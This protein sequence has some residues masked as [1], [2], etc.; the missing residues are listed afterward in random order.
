M[1]GLPS[2]VNGD[3]HINIDALLWV[4]W[5]WGP[6]GGH[7]IADLNSDG[8]VDMLDLLLALSNWTA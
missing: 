1:P 6:T 8:M 3:N 7:T 2:D 5:H 4:I